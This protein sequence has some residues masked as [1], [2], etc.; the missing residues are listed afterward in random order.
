MDGSGSLFPDFKHYLRAVERNLGSLYGISERK[1]RI[2]RKAILKLTYHRFA[3]VHRLLCIFS[4]QFPWQVKMNNQGSKLPNTAPRDSMTQHH[5]FSLNSLIFKGKPKALRMGSDVLQE[6]DSL[7]GNGAVCSGN[8]CLAFW[9][10]PNCSLC[11]TGTSVSQPPDDS[12][13]AKEMWAGAPIKY[14]KH[15]S[16]LLLT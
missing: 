7:H 5:S 13:T 14:V 12:P 10:T 2:S 15:T 16:P 9:S 6:A 1:T 8:S 11:L 4:L 3:K